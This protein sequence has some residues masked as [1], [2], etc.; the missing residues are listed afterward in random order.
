MLGERHSHFSWIAAGILAALAAWIGSGLERPVAEDRARAYALSPGVLEA[1][2]D[3]YAH[4]VAAVRWME[5]LDRVGGWFLGEGKPDYA[6]LARELDLIT[7]WNPHAE[8]AY[9]MAAV[10]IPWGTGKTE[11]SRPLLLR[12]M[13]VMPED[14]R[15][16]FYR[17]F[18]AYWFERDRERA[19]RLL[20]LAAT[21]PGAPPLVMRLAARMQASAGALD[22]AQSFL[23]ELLHTT[24]DRKL[25]TE[26]RRQ[27]LAVRT[28]RILRRLDRA[29]A[30]IPPEK[31]SRALLARLG[32]LPPEPL[33]DGGIVVF[34]K[35][36]EPVSSKLGK[37]FRIFVPPHRRKGAR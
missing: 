31:R 29:I 35:R 11:L 15:W 23:E 6:W 13:G 34:D 30:H 12:A 5:V 33:P 1:L 20:A 9:F 32:L 14:W 2:P 19:A 16:P 24:R 18:N 37:R 10:M 28:E 26:I 27:L 36:G 25:R 22:A 7:R 4:L 3:G 17:G 8:H 21:K